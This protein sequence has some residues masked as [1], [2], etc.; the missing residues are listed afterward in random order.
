MILIHKQRVDGWIDGH[1][2]PCLLFRCFQVI[3]AGGTRFLL[4]PLILELDPLE[5]R[6]LLCKMQQTER[7][8]EE[9]IAAGGLPTLVQYLDLVQYLGHELNEFT[10]ALQAPEL[11]EL[12]QALHAFCT[13]SK[14]HQDAVCQVR[15]TLFIF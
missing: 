14:A 5:T 1:L 3:T 8:R 2:E 12:A 7:G 11:D 10:R 15:R 6:H 13:S 9:L 4:E